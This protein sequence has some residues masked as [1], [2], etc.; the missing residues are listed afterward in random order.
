HRD[1]RTAEA[2]DH[3]GRPTQEHLHRER[4]GAVGR[5]VAAGT[6]APGT[7]DGTGA[8]ATGRPTRIGRDA[9]PAAAAPAA[10]RALLSLLSNPVIP[11]AVVPRSLSSG[12]SPS[13]ILPSSHASNSLRAIGA[14]AEPP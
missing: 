6:G 9:S 2:H 10:G 5:A 8:G 3:L 7:G 11:I 12:S 1:Q 14:A 13:G 4:S